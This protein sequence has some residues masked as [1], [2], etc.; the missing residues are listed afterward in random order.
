MGSVP[1]KTLTQA[2]KMKW[3][4]SKESDKKLTRNW[5]I[6]KPKKGM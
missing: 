6:L 1:Q 5:I 3:Q 4:S 2:A